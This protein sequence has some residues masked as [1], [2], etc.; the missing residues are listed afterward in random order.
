MRQTAK[1]SGYCAKPGEFIL[2][3]VLQKTSMCPPIISSNVPLHALATDEVPMR[4][5][6][7]SRVRRAAHAL[8]I[9]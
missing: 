8:I 6:K 5:Q 3:Y 9:V 4:K 7:D 2:K 1:K